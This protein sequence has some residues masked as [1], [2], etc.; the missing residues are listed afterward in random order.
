MPTTGTDADRVAAR[1]VDH[2]FDE[3]DSARHVRRA[4]TWIGFVLKAIQRATGQ[5][6][7]LDRQRQVT[8]MYRGISFKAR[9]EPHAGRRGSI[10]IVE[11]A[12]TQGSPDG[13]TVIRIASLDDAEQAYN[14]LER[15]LDQFVDRGRQ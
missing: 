8:F 7:R 9:Y 10:H 13:E 5:V 14:G 3:H 6:P 15:I 12:R 2:L 1:Y 11:V 4:A